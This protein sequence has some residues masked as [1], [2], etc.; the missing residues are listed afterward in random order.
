MSAAITNLTTDQWNVLK[1]I[2]D[3]K[4]KTTRKEQAAVVILGR[5]TPEAIGL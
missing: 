1:D 2:A 5:R 4:D 3:D